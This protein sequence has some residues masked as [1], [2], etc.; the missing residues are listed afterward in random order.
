LGNVDLT[1][2]VIIVGA[3]PAGS[4]AAEVLARASLRVALLEEHAQVGLPD[5]CSGLVS[6]RTLEAA[7]ISEE[8]VGKAWFSRAR[9]WGPGE[10]VLWLE[11]E[12]VQAVAIDRP[13]FDQ[14][15]AERAVEAGATLLLGTRARGF[16]RVDGHVRVKAERDG[17]QIYLRAPLLIGADGVVSRVARW[18]GLRLPQEVIPAVKGEICF[19]SGGTETIEVFVGRDV[20]PGWFGW[21]IPVGEGWARIGIGAVGSAR[22][23]FQPFLDRLRARFGPFSV[24]EVRGAAIPLGPARRFVAD[25]VMLVGAAARQT[26]P[27]TGGGVYLG[28]R[29]AQM[30]AQVALWALER[31]DC[32][33]RAL[34]GYERQWQRLE[35]H[36]VLVGHWLRRVFRR[37]SDREL[38]RIIAVL[39]RPWAQGI[40]SRLGDIDFPSRLFSAL[41]VELGRQVVPFGGGRTPDR[42]GEA[43]G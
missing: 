6:P 10:T 36:E 12:S 15:L 33:R 34:Q 4:T 30:A 13:R 7:R 29:A 9:V 31:G 27:T 26:K 42:V 28:V 43:V 32:S 23:F 40:I 5:H 18:A 38:G 21:L 8:M 16:E 11:S 37:L 24:R 14:I 2:D 19:Q 35:G 22:S 17:R 25:R 3:G 1:Y 20:A 41:L 39:N